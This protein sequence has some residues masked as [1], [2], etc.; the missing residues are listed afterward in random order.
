MLAPDRRGRQN[1]TH[2]L[3]N[4]KYSESGES[5][6]VRIADDDAHLKDIFDLDNAIQR[7][8]Q[9]GADEAARRTLVGTYHNLLRKWSDT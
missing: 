9:T 3:I 1:D 8:N 5:V 2:R 7:L 4:S 6:L